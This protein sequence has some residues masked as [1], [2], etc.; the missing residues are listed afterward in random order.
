MKPIDIRK[1]IKT[2]SG[3]W[4][5]ASDQIEASNV[6]KRD[7]YR[8]PEEPSYVSW[9][10]L[11][12]ESDGILKL[13]FTETTGAPD[14][15]PPTYNFNS[16]DFEWSRK[17]LV[18]RDGG[19][20]WSDTGWKEALGPSFWEL[21]SHH[22]GYHT[23]QRHDGVLLR[24]NP[25]GLE[26]IT[27]KTDWMIYDESKSMQDFPFTYK[28]TEVHTVFT[29]T[30]TSADGGRSWKEIHINREEPH[31]F[32]TGIHQLRNGS[33][34][35]TGSIRGNKA[36]L[37]ES[38]DGGKTW[39]APQV[40]AEDDDVLAPQGLTEENDFVELADG[41][42]LLIQRL[43]GAGNNNSQ[44]YLSRDGSGRWQ[45]TRPS[46]HPQ[47]IK[48]GYPYMHRAGDN[49][50][51]YYCDTAIRYTCDDGVSWHSLPLGFAYYGQL[52]ETRPGRILTVTQKNIGDCPYPW[53]H[54][55]S[56]LQTEFDYKRVGVVE[57][58]NPAV[59]AAISLINGKEYR[60]FHLYADIRA[61]G[62]TGLV[63]D[64]QKNSYAFAVVVIPCNEFRA[65]GRAAKAE[66]DASLILGKCES[67][68]VSV[69][70]RVGIGKIVP[71]SWVEMQVNRKG[72]MI[73]TAVKA[74][75]GDWMNGQI[76][77]AYLAMRREVKGPG[78]LGF[79]TNYSTGAFK[80]VRI[81]A[82]SAEIRSN[83]R[84]SGEG[85][86]RIALDAGRQE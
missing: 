5:I 59:L 64:V 56:M 69:L 46:T 80:N 42:L 57:Q 36:A 24:N 52:L 37:T 28:E 1:G 35:A 48:S 73:L 61:D 9:A 6:Q 45:A 71:G 23:F 49:T 8:S 21:N 40:F 43:G 50:I 54:D 58:T 39:N 77:A 26:G 29:A 13:S 17:T 4:I 75:E 41:R 31:F 66:Q 70:R 53:K 82:E 55:T 67:G 62:E 11:W 33:I 68:K 3:T 30:Q 79:F 20:T 27:K 51:F 72:D 34:V 83:W 65:P 86:R 47:F 78:K 2:F 32:A 15:W 76:P 14:A 16:R 44:M 38:W 63:F 10:I 81:G 84:V 60:D 19:E 18:S 85:A 12:K 25:H 74:R 7:I 22:R